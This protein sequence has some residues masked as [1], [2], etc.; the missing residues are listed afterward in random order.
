MHFDSRQY[1][2]CAVKENKKHR[3][4]NT[5]ENAVFSGDGVLSALRRCFGFEGQGSSAEQSASP[6]VQ[7]RG[8][9]LGSPAVA[10]GTF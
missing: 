4:K 3:D 9:L 10:A 6:P 5:P 7:T 2:A 1:S 8:V